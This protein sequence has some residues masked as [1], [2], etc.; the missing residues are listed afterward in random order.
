MI[1]DDTTVAIDDRPGRTRSFARSST[2]EAYA[3]WPPRRSTALGSR[4]SLLRQPAEN[5][6]RTDFGLRA[7][8]EGKDEAFELGPARRI[9]EVALV[10]CG[11]RPS[12]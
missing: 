4:P 3:C 1:A 6:L 12:E 7:F 5:R 10:F 2:N 11:S 9:E 8:A